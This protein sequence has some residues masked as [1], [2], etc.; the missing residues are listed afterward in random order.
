MT[1][2][3]RLIA[4]L[5]AA[6]WL[7]WRLTQVKAG[8]L[9]GERATVAGIDYHLAPENVPVEGLDYDPT[10]LPARLTAKLETT[11]AEL[12]SRAQH[13]TATPTRRRPRRVRV[14]S[15]AT[16]GLLALGAAGA[17][18]AALVT[19]STGVPA[20]DRLLGTYEAGPEDPPS[21]DTTRQGLQPG[22]SRAS[23]TVEVPLDGRRLLVTSYVASD[24]RVCSVL[25]SGDGSEPRGDLVCI[26][27][28]LLAARLARTDGVVVGSNADGARVVI[29]GFVSDR[30]S[31]VTGRGPNG[32]VDVHLGE[33]WMPGAPATGPV[34][35]FVAVG[36][37]GD[38]GGPNADPL[39]LANPGGYTFDGITDD[40]EEIPIAR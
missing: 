1:A 33:K 35:A 28:D 26:Q 21:T 18:A 10:E 32:P 2:P 23:T 13:P 29:R 12:R 14:A 16:A 36:D 11:R 5:W 4:W 40:G 3:R 19:G 15:L 9:L 30:V 37:V 6:V 38:A 24:G 8:L 31:R 17:G 7:R 22:S 20:V 25:P 39:R 27:P 34:R